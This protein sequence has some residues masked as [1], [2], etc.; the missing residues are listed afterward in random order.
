MPTRIQ[1]KISDFYHETWKVLDR[2]NGNIVLSTAWLNTDNVILSLLSNYFPKQMKH[3]KIM[4]IDTLDL[5]DETHDISKEVQETY[6]VK[7]Y[8]YKPEVSFEDFKIK[9]KIEDYDYYCKVEPFQRGLIDLRKDIL[10]TGRRHDQGNQRLDLQ[11]WEQDKR[12]YNPL[13]EWTWEDVTQYVDVAKV[14]TSKLY[15]TVY[16]SND[17]IDIADRH[18]PAIPWNKY[19]LSQPFW[20]YSSKELY[21]NHK[22]VYVMKS[23]G[24]KKTTVPIEP[25]R[26]EREGR[27]VNKSSSECGIHTRANHPSKVNKKIS[28]KNVYINENKKVRKLELNERQACDTEMLIHDAF[29]PLH[30]F[31]DRENY[32][33]VIYDL[34]LKSGDVFGM[35]IT[36]DVHGKYDM[37]EDV[38]LTYKGTDVALLNIQDIYTATPYEESKMVYGTTSL[39]HPGVHHLLRRNY[40]YISGPLTGLDSIWFNKTEGFKSPKTVKEENKDKGPILAFQ[41]RNPIHRAHFE[42]MLN[43][44]KQLGNAHILVHPTCGPTQPNDI[45]Y[46][47]RIKTYEALRKNEAKGANMSWAYLPYS[48]KMAGPREVIQHMIIRKNFGCNY[49]IVGRDMAGTKN[50]LTGEDFYGPYDAHK[51]ADKYK[52]QIGIG[53]VKSKNIVYT[54]KGYITEEEASNKGLDIKKLSGTKFRDMLKNNQCIPEWFSFPSVLKVLKDQQT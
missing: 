34:K 7:P 5:F 35:P 18:K 54:D 13:L 26:T 28:E 3:I 10:I 25:Y 27:F 16:R 1:N 11:L 44:Q 23:F 48:M 14:P 31:M 42:L 46:L 51:L 53:I 32:Y 49:M 9:S 15:N 30:T 19:K 33:S 17:E 21:D 50:N 40:K 52:E 37:N 20:R 43:L 4:S 22:K 39:Y 38:I 29:K 6:K 24:D 41:C 8:I 45:D 12:I 2:R 47:S 36:L